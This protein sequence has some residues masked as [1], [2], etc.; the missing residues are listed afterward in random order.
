[1]AKESESSQLE[2]SWLIDSK[3]KEILVLT[4]LKYRI[5]ALSCLLIS[6]K[7]F[8]YEVPQGWRVGNCM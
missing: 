2:W 1:M 3:M 7:L 8:L 4:F 5:L 6:W